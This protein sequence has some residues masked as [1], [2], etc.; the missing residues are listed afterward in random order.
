M[1]PSRHGDLECSE[2]ILWEFSYG[3]KAFMVKPEKTLLLAGVL[4]NL[5]MRRELPRRPKHELLGPKLRLNN[6]RCSP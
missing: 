6:N 4:H 2:N 3:S 1:K 5:D